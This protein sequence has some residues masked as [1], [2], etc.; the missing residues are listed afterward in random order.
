MTT[1]KRSYTAPAGMIISDVQLSEDKKTLIT[2]FEQEKPKFKRGDFVHSI[3]SCSV[4]FISIYGDEKNSLYCINLTKNKTCMTYVSSSE[5]FDRLANSNEIKKIVDSLA[6]EDK[7]WN[8]D[9]LC[10]EHLKYVPKVGDCIEFGDG[11]G[12]L[13]KATN[14][15]STFIVGAWRT[16]NGKIVTTET[17]DRVDLSDGKFENKQIT[18]EQL[19]AKFNAIGY[20]YDFETHTASKIRWK[21]KVEE[22]YFFIESTGRIAHT[23]YCGWGVDKDRFLFGNC[24]KDRQSAEK[25]LNYIKQYKP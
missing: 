25:L 12:E 13:I 11:F 19:Q 8:S 24:F 3:N 18:P 16:E 1:Q 23:T 20:E 14:V 17:G 15:E 2:I 7:Q 9:K 21:P 4:E 5:T 6:K 10:I 22:E